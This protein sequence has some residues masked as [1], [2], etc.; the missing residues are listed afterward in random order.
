MDLFRIVKTADRARDLSGIGAYLH[1]G[2]WNSKG[3]YLLYTSVNSSLALL[4]SLVHFDPLLIPPRLYLTRLV[5][6]DR[7]PVF[8]LAD[9]HYPTGWKSGEWAENKK[10]GDQFARDNKF[11]ALRVR[12]V[13]NEQE[14]NYLLNPQFPEYTD[15]LKVADVSEIPV[16][17]RLRK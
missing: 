2:R 5:F 3:T 16:D 15:I 14:Y 10:L 17:E 8:S 11:V 1:G 13:V 9:K 12:S 7:A 6:D 4:E